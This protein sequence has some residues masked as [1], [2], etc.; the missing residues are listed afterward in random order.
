MKKITN[1][2]LGRILMLTLALLISI[3]GVLTKILLNIFPQWEIIF[4]NAL[5][6]L[7]VSLIIILFKG[8]N[9][10]KVQNIPK[11]FIRVFSMAIAFIIYVFSIQ[12][13][14]IVEVM[15]IYNFAPVISTVLAIF[16]LKEKFNI[17]RFIAVLFGFVGVLIIIKPGEGLFSLTSLLPILG[18]FFVGIAYVTTRSIMKIDNVYA[19]VFYYSVGLLILSLV[20]FP[21]NFIL[22]SLY[23]LLL[24][25]LTGLLS[26]ISHYLFA[27]SVK[28]GEVSSVAPLEYTAFIWTGLLGYLVFNQIPNLMV[29]FGGVIIIISGIYLIR[30]ENN[31]FKYK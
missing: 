23:L 31:L 7:I 22:P 29:I 17:L 27:L 5:T 3:N 10:F 2:N 6:C 24:L 8:T 9:N 30:V 28:F 16:F 26:I 12:K 20:F 11:H 18:A 4:F 19:T 14:F 21:K 15:A 13:I 1:I 25:L